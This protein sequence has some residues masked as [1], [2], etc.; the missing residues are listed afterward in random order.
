MKPTAQLLAAALSAQGALAQVN[1]PP[2][3]RPEQDLK[4]QITIASTLDTTVPLQPADADVWDLDLYHVAR[5]PEIVD[6]LRVS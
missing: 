3:F 1:P 6:F 2:N 4:F 5:H